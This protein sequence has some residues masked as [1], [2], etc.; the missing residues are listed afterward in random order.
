MNSNH[1][2]LCSSREWAERLQSEVLAPLVR[3]NGIGGRMIEIGPGPGAATE[4]LRRHVEHL[5]V[6]EA[7]P[8]A[9]A[10][11][12]ARFDD[13]E[14]VPGD[15][16]AL[17]YPEGE[18]DAAGSF[19][20]LHHVPTREAQ[21]RVLAELV[22]VLRPGGVLVG[23]D[24]LASDGLREFHEGDTYNP[25]PPSHLLDR[26]QELGCS[27]ITVTVDRVLTFTARKR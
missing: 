21:D 5:V 8:E 1:A 11:L 16:A 20:M 27:R 14:V 26:L 24:S 15:A 17:P 23:S 9:A 18:F 4:W 13:V 19:T 25:I 7:D 10:A 12:A 22:R 6:V 3:D 2:A